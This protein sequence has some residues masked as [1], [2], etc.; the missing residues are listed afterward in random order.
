MSGPNL[1]RDAPHPVQGALG[2]VD[3]IGQQV[4]RLDQT[5]G[6]DLGGIIRR[7]VG[8]HQDRRGIEAFDQQAAFIVAGGVHRAEHTA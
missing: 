5:F 6:L 7:I 1:G 3:M 8:H 2:D 4:F